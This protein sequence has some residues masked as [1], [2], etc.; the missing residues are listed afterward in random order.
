MKSAITVIAV[1]ALVVSV[2][3]ARAQLPRTDAIWA[4]QATAGSIT[5]DGNL[6]E[7][8]WAQA[9][10]IN[11]HYGI[12]AGIPGSGWK[13]EG[14]FDPTMADNDS[15]N[16]TLRFLV[17]GNKLYLGATVPDKSIGGGGGFNYFD[18]FLMGLKNHTDPNFPKPIDEYLHSWW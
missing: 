2:A 16:A 9:E 13:P 18:G 10:K 12:S 7:P 5:L 3:P 4:R 8:V 14:G 17:I 1:L 6:N 11:L 15:T